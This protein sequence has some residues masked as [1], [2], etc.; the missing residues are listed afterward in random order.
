[1]L[2]LSPR[3]CR[4]PRCPARSANRSGLPLPYSASRSS[5]RASLTLPRSAS[6]SS[7]RTASRYPGRSASSSPVR[8]TRVGAFSQ[9]YSPASPRIEAAAGESVED[10]LESSSALVILPSSRAPIK[11]TICAMERW[12]RPNRWCKGGG[13]G[14]A[15]LA[16]RSGGWRSHGGEEAVAGVGWNILER[17]SWTSR[18]SVCSFS[19]PRKDWHI[20][21]TER[22]I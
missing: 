4:P 8:S 20:C 17:G 7:A 22:E 3:R 12:R 13:N 1:A 18:V 10:D 15:R 16:T 19:N 9:T 2:H 21:Q 14:E 6:R 5:A 11:A